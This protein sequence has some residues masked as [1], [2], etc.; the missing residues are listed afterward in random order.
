MAWR[1]LYSQVSNLR[2][3]NMAR[4]LVVEPDRL[5]ADIYATSLRRNGHEVVLAVSAG[6]ALRHLEAGVDILL[7]EIQLV[8]HN[9]LE[10]LYEIRSYTDLTDVRT[11]IHTMLPLDRMP[12][13]LYQQLGVSEYLYKPSTTL[14]KL[15]ETVCNVLA[16]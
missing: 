12:R 9:G 2:W 14:V 3:S 7:L 13:V 6:E 16:Q 10:L 11:I 1:P 5:L 15:N 4:V 8:V